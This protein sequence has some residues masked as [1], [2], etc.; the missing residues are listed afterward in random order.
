MF[1]QQLFNGVLLGATF[2]LIA[3]GFNLVV[4]ALDKLNFALG[5]TAMVS[6]IMASL[7][8]VNDSLP[9]VVTFV[10]CLVGGRRAVGAD[11]LPVLPVRAPGVPDRI[12]PQQPRRRP[13]PHGDRDQAVRQ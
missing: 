11:V 3:L 9:F 8:M 2:C 5:E 1:T 13:G 4:G 6:A 7:L 12:D 10:A